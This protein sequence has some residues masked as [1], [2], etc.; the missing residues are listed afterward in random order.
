ML[1]RVLH[2]VSSFDS[3]QSIVTAMVSLDD[4]QQPVQGY[5][6]VT[7]YQYN[8]HFVML[9]LTFVCHSHYA[10]IAIDLV[11]ANVTKRCAHRLHDLLSKRNSFQ[12]HEDEKWK[13]NR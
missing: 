11:C 7:V 3:T 12:L 4:A 10:V 9:M 1:A 6:V 5:S 8:H 2:S 13:I